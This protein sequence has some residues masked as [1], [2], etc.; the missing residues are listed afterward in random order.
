M[1][2]EAAVK[3]YIYDWLVGLNI[4]RV[5]QDRMSR[6]DTTKLQNKRTYIIYDFPEGIEDQGPWYYATCVVCIGCRN[7]DRFVPDLATLDSVC[8]KFKKEFDK[9]DEVEG[10]SCIDV[11]Y[12]DDYPDELGNYEYQYI[13]DVYAS[14]C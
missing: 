2:S 1:R 11:Q 13:F 8:E 12:L 3:K 9:N 7:K 6:G 5:Y 14:K 4:G 10:I